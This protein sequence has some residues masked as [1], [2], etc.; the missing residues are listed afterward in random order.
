MAVMR[1]RPY[2]NSNFL[3]DLGDEDGGSVSAGFA[4]VI[5]PAFSIDWAERRLAES[6]LQGAEAT[7]AGDG[8]RLVLMETVELAFD[9]ME[10]S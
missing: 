10:M 3:V 8:N 1:E 2:V 6:R 9:S 5:F 4:E 7:S